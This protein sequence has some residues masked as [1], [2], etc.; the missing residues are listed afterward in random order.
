MYTVGTSGILGF[1]RPIQKCSMNMMSQAG[2]GRVDLASI[3]LL[4]FCAF[5]ALDRLRQPHCAGV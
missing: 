2:A 3:V 5:E 4:P 1:C